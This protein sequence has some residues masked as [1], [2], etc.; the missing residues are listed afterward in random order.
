MGFRGG[1]PGASHDV[2]RQTAI[3][4]AFDMTAILALD[5]GS[6]HDITHIDAMIERRRADSGGDTSGVETSN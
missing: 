4:L 5:L 6:V 1:R 2:G 3:A